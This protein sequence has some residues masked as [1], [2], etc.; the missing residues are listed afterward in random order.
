MWYSLFVVDSRA[1][2]W[3]KSESF[4]FVAPPRPQYN[5]QRRANCPS[6]EGRA[7]GFG[8]SQLGLREASI[9]GGGAISA[10]IKQIE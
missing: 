3:K 5:Y 7:V 8:S 9:G 1:P 4:P 6:I 10:H 2:Y